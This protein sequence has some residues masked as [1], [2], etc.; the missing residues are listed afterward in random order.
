MIT[1]KYISMTYVYTEVCLNGVLSQRSISPL[2]M[3]TPKYVSMTY[4]HTEACLNM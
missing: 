2:C 1:H 3:I 4:D